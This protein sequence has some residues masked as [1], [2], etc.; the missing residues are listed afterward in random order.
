MTFSFLT[1]WLRDFAKNNRYYWAIT[2]NIPILELVN[3]CFFQNYCYGIS[4]V[5]WIRVEPRLC[6]N[7][8][9]TIEVSVLTSNSENPRECL[10]NFSNVNCDQHNNVQFPVVHK[11]DSAI[12]WINHYP[13]DNASS[14]HYPTLNNRG[15]DRRAKLRNH[16]L[17][18][19]AVCGLVI[20]LRLICFFIAT[21]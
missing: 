11:L 5:L 14:F 17:N 13:V 18:T 6:W 7:C 21:Q 2:W 3:I 20:F 16:K 15:Q 4:G 8:E 10:K 12:H 19:V 1:R 9:G